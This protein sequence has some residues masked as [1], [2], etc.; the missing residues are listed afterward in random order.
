MLPKVLQPNVPQSLSIH[1]ALPSAPSE[2][3]APFNSILQPIYLPNKLHY[4]SQ[5][6]LVPALHLPPV[7]VDLSFLVKTTDCEQLP[8]LNV[9]IYSVTVY[10]LDLHIVTPPVLE[11]WT[12]IRT[13]Q[14]LRTLY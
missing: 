11:L 4:P 10:S 3:I 6:D 8:S 9:Y 5:H 12:V 1:L 13:E 14:V 2:L 7:C